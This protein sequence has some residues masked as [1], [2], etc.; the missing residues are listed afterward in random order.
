[1]AL[2]L[3]LASAALVASLCTAAP[4]TAGSVSV[5]RAEVSGPASTSWPAFIDEY[6]P[7]GELL[8]TISL[9][10]QN[11]PGFLAFSLSANDSYVGLIS[12][13]SSR[14]ALL[15]V[16]YNAEPGTKKVE[17]SFSSMTR[18]LVAV[19]WAD[20]TVDTTTLDVE[21]FGGDLSQ[22]GYIRCAASDDMKD[23]WISGESLHNAGGAVR[24]INFTAAV[25]SPVNN[26]GLVLSGGNLTSCS[27]YGSRLFA[28][29][30]GD[31]ALYAL[32]D[33]HSFEPGLPGAVIN[34]A[35]AGTYRNVTS[36]SMTAGGPPGFALGGPLAS[37]RVW[38]SSSTQCTTAWAYDPAGEARGIAGPLVW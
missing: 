3:K 33:L 9:P 34:P 8:Q 29:S 19:I 2:T 13:A 31:G 25:T 18:R 21:E 28:A 4:F 37:P 36:G 35:F 17:Y 30:D 32:E 15:L 11:G 20:G 14:E 12:R 1:M 38:T 10:V 22:P 6:L 5:L 23:V 7:S 24:I 16:G 27:V 26:A